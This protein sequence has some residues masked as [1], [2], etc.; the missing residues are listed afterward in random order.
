MDSA[1]ATLD[2]VVVVL[3]SA[4]G[5]GSS[6]GADVEVV[7]DA[8]GFGEGSSFFS[9]VATGVFGTSFDGDDCDVGADDADAAAFGP[10]FTITTINFF[11]SMLYDE[12]TLPSSSIHP[13]IIKEI[14]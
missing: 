3:G 7:E 10:F 2:G 5:V 4:E 9:V 12:T 8:G 6:F 14:Y 11:S 1:W 13:A